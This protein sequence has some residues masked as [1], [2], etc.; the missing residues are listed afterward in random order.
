MGIAMALAGPGY[1]LTDNE[2][3]IVDAAR[4]PIA[5][6]LELFATGQGQHEHPPLWD[7][8]LHGW[9]R[10]GGAGPV[11][12][13][14]P[15]IACYLAGCLLLRAFVRRR[16]NDAA[17]HR[18][19][20]MAALWPFAWQ[21]APSP[22]WYSLG[23]LEVAWLLAAVETWRQCPSPHRA[24][25]VL[26]AGTVLLYTN[27]F[28]VAIIAAVLV[29][30]AAAHSGDGPPC[31]RRKLM[32]FV[33]FWAL[34]FVPL[35]PALATRLHT[36]LSLQASALGMAAFA[37]HDA[38]A[39][40]LAEAVAPWDLPLALPAWCAAVVLSLALAKA[41]RGRGLLLAFA[42]LFLTLAVAG[43]ARTERLLFLTPLA[44]AGIAI[45][46]P[47]GWPRRLV[48]LTL[49]LL[50]LPGW[51]GIV[52][53]TH[54]VSTRRIEP[55]PA[56]GVEAAAAVHDGALIVANN[57]VFFFY[58]SQAL[59]PDKPL[60]PMLPWGRTHAAVHE[61]IGWRRS[62][63]PLHREVWW[64][65]GVSNRV[66]RVAM[67]DAKADLL[68]RCHVH[69][70]RQPIADPAFQ[71]RQRLLRHAPATRWRVEVIVFECPVS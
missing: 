60:D 33:P 65:A 8:L 11:W 63:A 44:L 62:G 36:D 29:E 59:A 61:P 22:G 55:W 12:L 27:Y 57:P 45:G 39:L 7:L 51:L 13:R 23:F 5:K 3:T 10:L 21:F 64:V 34:A 56:L 40:V 46:L 17:A 9:L 50:V 32:M 47:S 54:Y 15:G 71:W 48:P 38:A 31:P 43:L 49:I 1:S 35:L 4:A 30:Q 58:L 42:A 67:D 66:R 26:L 69:T 20:A 37:A 6:T 53:R 18:V 52:L 14:L 41:R 68:A 16:S 70:Q 25:N 24:A 19:V 28:G 2:V